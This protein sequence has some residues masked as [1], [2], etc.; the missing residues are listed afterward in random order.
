MP[1]RRCT[2]TVLPTICQ[3]AVLLLAV[4]TVAAFSPTSGVA[5]LHPAGRSLG[6]HAAPPEARSGNSMADG[7]AADAGVAVVVAEAS[8]EDVN[9]EYSAR[10]PDVIPAGFA[11]TC[12]QMR[13][14]PG[15]MWKQLSDGRRL[16]FEA[17]NGSYIYWNRCVSWARVSPPARLSCRGLGPLIPL[18]GSGSHA[19]ALLSSD[20]GYPPHRRP[21]TSCVADFHL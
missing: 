11:A 21:Q 19:D 10:S 3:R 1:T 13:W 18:L 14:E 2:D 6:A 9:G 20:A 15:Q 7:C 5:A 12:A 17:E 16:W 4:S 8:V